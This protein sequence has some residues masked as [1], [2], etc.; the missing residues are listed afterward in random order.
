MN[1]WVIWIVAVAQRAEARLSE[2]QQGEVGA[3]FRR[4]YQVSFQQAWYVLEDEIIE[5]RKLTEIG[6]GGTQ[7]AIA[8]RAVDRLVK[9][10]A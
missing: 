7:A 5:Q 8:D 2:R 6:G 3:M 9:E 4:T 10:L 1:E